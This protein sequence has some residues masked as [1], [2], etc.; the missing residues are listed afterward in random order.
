MSPHDSYFA[1]RADEERRIA[2]ASADRKV[3]RLHLE[4]AAR[5]AVA[6]GTDVVLNDEV[7]IQH[8]QRTA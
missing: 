1:A 7:P 3:R 2:M 4:M 6:A 8:A 5:Y